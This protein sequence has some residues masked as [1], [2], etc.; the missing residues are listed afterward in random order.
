MKYQINTNALMQ[1]KEMSAWELSLQNH[2]AIKAILAVFL[3][4][5]ICLTQEGYDK[6]DDSLKSLFKALK[7]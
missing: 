7:D 4:G 3:A 5:D 6:L 1:E 2:Q